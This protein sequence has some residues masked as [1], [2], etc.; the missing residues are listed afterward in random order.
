MK[1]EDRNAKA[2][3]RRLVR[4]LEDLLENEYHFRDYD[5]LPQSEFGKVN[6]IAVHQCVDSNS[7]ERD[8]EN[9]LHSFSRDG[10]SSVVFYVGGVQ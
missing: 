8:I 10:F 3:Q 7:M 6:K 1:R 4:K 2:K 9:A 5:I